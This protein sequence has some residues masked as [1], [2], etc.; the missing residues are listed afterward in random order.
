M[1]DDWLWDGTPA[2]GADDRRIAEALGGL[3]R[4]RTCPPLPHR[5]RR[6]RRVWA[7][8]LTLAA[9][10]LLA[11]LLRP[12]PGRWT[13]T[14]LAGPSPCGAPTCTLV[15]GEGLEVGPEGRLELALGWV[16]TVE[17]GPGTRLER[18]RGDGDYVL[19]VHEGTV[20]VAAIAP[21]RTV[22][23]HTPAA[24]VVDLGCAYTLV[25]DAAGTDL[26]VGDGSVALETARGVSVV[27]A[28]S[29]ASAFPGRRPE[30]PVREDA[31]P[32]FH[33]AVRALDAGPGGRVAPQDGDLDEVLG[34]ARPEDLFTLWHVLQRVAA[35][36][37]PRVLDRMATSVPLTDADRVA[38]LRLDG[39]ALTRLWQGMV[40]VALGP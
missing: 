19:E 6:P 9:V 28:G 27:T 36:D 34:L 25:V 18:L 39:D 7:V 5:P 21:P 1:S 12:D 20:A 37:R 32:A 33:D 40:P 16:G 11:L 35:A 15:E 2:E 26:R 31:V 24:T 30:T 13:V 8:G 3:G 23:I 38:L 4:D 14:V 10:A 29:R 22:R 17:V